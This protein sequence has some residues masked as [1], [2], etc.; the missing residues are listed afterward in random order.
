MEEYA[1]LTFNETNDNGHYRD[2]IELIVD[3]IPCELFYHISKGEWNFEI[4]DRNIRE[5]EECD[6]SHT[7]IEKMSPLHSKIFPEFDKDADITPAIIEKFV[8]IILKFLDSVEFSKVDGRF[9]SKTYCRKEKARNIVF[10]K[11][12]E[13]ETPENQCSVC[14]D[15]TKTKTPCGHKLCIPCWIQIKNECCPLCRGDISYFEKED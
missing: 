4:Q 6:M 10:E 3:N 15:I 1:I 2:S 5:S 9:L 12:L 13:K 8:Q 14:M 11:Y 7:Y